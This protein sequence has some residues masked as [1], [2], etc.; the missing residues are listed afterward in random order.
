MKI[1]V[2]TK[3]VP[4][5]SEMIEVENGKVNLEGIPLVINNWDEYAVEAA[6]QLC[7]KYDG[8]TIAISL[9]DDTS[10]VALQHALAM[11]CQDAFQISEENTEDN[12]DSLGA[13]RVFASAI[14]TIVDTDIVIFGKQATDNDSGLLAAQTARV[15]GWPILSYV[16]EIESYQADQ[17]SIRLVRQ[18]EESAQIIKATLPVVLTVGKDFGIPR[19]PSFIGI[20]KA[21]KKEIP[22]WSFKDIGVTPS[23]K[24]LT[25]IN[26]I[27]AP[28]RDTDCQFIEGNSPDEIANN[29]LEKLFERGII[30]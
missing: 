26:N 30:K 3:V 10:R 6:L 12:L 21:S 18:M 28:S 11:G 9:G 25:V 14:Q 24:H 15:L 19:Y 5:S 20:R 13:A 22:N 29:L 16:S 4:D 8:E 27:Q 23:K 7:E 1:V 17:K 2:C